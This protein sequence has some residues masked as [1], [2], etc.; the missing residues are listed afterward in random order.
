MENPAHHRKI[1]AFCDQELAPKLFL[2]GF[3]QEYRQDRKKGM[4]K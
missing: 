3:L 4:Q 1:E 2:Q